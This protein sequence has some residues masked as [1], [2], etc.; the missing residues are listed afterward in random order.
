MSEVFPPELT[1]RIIGCI[2][3]CERKTLCLCSL[4]SRKWLPASRH[5]LFQYILINK[6]TTFDLL[7]TRVLHSESARPWLAVVRMLIIVESSSEIWY[8]PSEGHAITS[9]CT[10]GTDDVARTKT[11][12]AACRLFLYQFSGYLPELSRLYLSGINWQ[13]YATPH[14]SEP[15]LL[16]QFPALRSLTLIN[17]RLPSLHFLRRALVA[18]PRLRNLLLSLVTWPRP[19]P[20]HTMKPV[21][22]CPLTR[23]ELQSLRIG[24][25]FSQA[26]M[27]S[28]P[29]VSSNGFLPWLSGTLS[30]HSLLFLDVGEIWAVEDATDFLD[31]VELVSP[32]LMQLTI[33]VMHEA[34]L[35]SLRR[36]EELYIKMYRATSWA[37]LCAQ[38]RKLQCPLVRL[39]IGPVPSSEYMEWAPMRDTET[40]FDE[41]DFEG[42][43]GVLINLQTLKEVTI[44]VSVPETYEDTGVLVSSV[45][46]RLSKLHQHGVQLGVI[47]DRHH[48]RPSEY[49]MVDLQ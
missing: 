43:D 24:P 35:A 36:L 27:S 11:V 17:C 6:A 30:R 1:D 5:A 9:K 23:P 25:H 28:T 33:P 10:R 7:V 44:V 19:G 48:K 16:S 29:R 32:N 38:L 3:P 2:D 39:K 4:V 34:P 49:R 37:A 45:E 31:F 47:L 14:S 18:L 8:S 41:P 20:L 26:P 21:H 13:L 40:G 12:S 22:A 46:S 15:L 42:L